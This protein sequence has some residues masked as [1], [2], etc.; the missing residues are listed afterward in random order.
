MMITLKMK[1]FDIYLW[2]ILL[3]RP[4]GLKFQ[5]QIVSNEETEIIKNQIFSKKLVRL[6]HP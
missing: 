3:L 2:E 5:N 6:N 4:L 1:I